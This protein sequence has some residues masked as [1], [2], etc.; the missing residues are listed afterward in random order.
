MRSK[1]T[2][3]LV[4]V[5][6]VLGSTT[7]IAANGADIGWSVLAGGG[8]RVA[9][10]ILTLDNTAGQALA[11]LASSG[12]TQLCAGFWCQGETPRAVYLPLLLHRSAH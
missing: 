3:G 4:L 12:T 8:G 7:V 2:V 5:L 6:I 10:G 11:G 1:I 9:A